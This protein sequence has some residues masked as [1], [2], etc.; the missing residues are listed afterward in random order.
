VDAFDCIHMRNTLIHVAAAE[1]TAILPRCYASQKPGGLLLPEE[2]D[3]ST[4]QATEATPEPLRARYAEGVAAVL[5]VYA[6]RGLDLRLGDH[7]PALVT[8]AGF[9]VASLERRVREVAG[10]SAEARFHQL[11]FAQLASTVADDAAAHAAISRFLEVFAD[12][13]LG[14][15]TRTTVALVARKPP[16]A[17]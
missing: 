8:A 9:A 2:S 17:G 1:H 16:F 14:Y 7:L 6:R 13:G 4:W 12:P 10:G 5:A 15:H 11:S 3:L